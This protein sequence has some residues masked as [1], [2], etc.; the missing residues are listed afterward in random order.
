MNIP[1]RLSRI[2]A[3]NQRLDGAVKLSLSEFEPWFKGSHLPF[4]PEYTDHGVEHLEEVLV[5]ASSLI[6][7]EAWGILT[8]GDAAVLILSVLLHDCAMHLSE[9]SFV[10]L[11][12]SPAG[13][14]SLPLMRDSPWNA[15]WEGFLGEASRF[16][17]RKLIS[18][19]GDPKPVRRPPLDPVLMEKRDRMLIGEFIRRH[20]ARLAQEIAIFGVPSASPVPLSLQGLGR[21]SAEDYRELA[22]LIARSHGFSV[23]ALLP[24]LEDRFGQAARRECRGVH[25]TFLMVVLRIADYLQIRAERAPEQLLQVTQLRSPFSQGEWRAHHAIRDVRQSFDDPEAIFIESHPSDVETFFR[26]KDWCVG[27]QRELDESWAVLGEVYGR[28]NELAPLGIVIRRIRSNIEDPRGFEA[29]TGFVP[30]RARF[31][32]ADADLLT[33]LIKPLY[34]ESSSIGMREL[35]QNAIDAVRELHQV[36]KDRG[37]S[38]VDVEL[39]DQAADVICA[40]EQDSGG[41]HWATVSDRGIGMSTEVVT[42]YF[43]TAGAS[44]RR[45]D[46][47]RRTFEDDAG[48]SR[49]MRAGRFGIGALAAFLLGNELNVSTRHIDSSEGVEFTATVDAEVVPLRH[50]KRPVGTTIKIPV[51]AHVAKALSSEHWSDFQANR[52]WDWYVLQH[53]SVGRIGLDGP[54]KQ[55]YR[56]KSSGHRIARWLNFDFPGYDK[57]HWRY[58]DGPTLAC[59]GMVIPDHPRS[60]HSGLRLPNLIVND[61]DGHFPLNLQRST[62]S[63]A[64]PFDDELQREL[65]R[66]FCAFAISQLPCDLPCLRDARLALSERPF[67]HI[68]GFGEGGSSPWFFTSTHFGLCT[69]AVLKEAGVTSLVIVRAE[70]SLYNTKSFERSLPKNTAFV[71]LAPSSSAKDD[72]DTSNTLAMA[73]AQL[74]VSTGEYGSGYYEL[75][76]VIDLLNDLGNGAS[77]VLMTQRAFDYC[78]AHFNFEIVAEA[79]IEESEGGWVTLAVGGARQGKAPLKALTAQ[80]S[81]RTMLPFTPCLVEA[82]LDKNAMLSEMPPL[83]AA[84]LEILGNP[85][86]PIDR[87]QRRRQFAKQFKALAPYVRAAATEWGRPVVNA[88]AKRAAKHSAR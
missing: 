72:F 25:P 2:L 8:P 74:D 47:W 7:D 85:L 64:I 67:R 16:D 15:L 59:N 81:P 30:V 14:R 83:V 17:A 10:A 1:P 9:D 82:F 75:S 41:Q 29:E 39:T 35:M 60:Y 46:Y 70:S 27:I 44:F 12:S 52:S 61:P 20:H 76:Y 84:W 11:V 50:I 38:T 49:V 88:G 23:R 43:L 63:T 13:T 87:N 37:K 6:R 45:S 28:V 71:L 80:C 58:G 57:I 34:G 62:L 51:A 66:Y 22:G 73:A 19:F 68:E 86:I 79:S 3:Q 77:R 36:L 4:F 48:H 78:N 53:P 26:V 24:F 54:L 18:L 42:D 40:I 65:A 31:K 33:L 69:P 56:L 55:R 32:S 21:T 5:S